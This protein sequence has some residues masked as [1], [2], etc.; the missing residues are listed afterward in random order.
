MTQGEFLYKT[1]DIYFKN[2][3]E[4]IPHENKS[5]FFNVDEVEIYKIT[6]TH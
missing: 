2:F 4:I 1:N 5:R 3:N 6:L